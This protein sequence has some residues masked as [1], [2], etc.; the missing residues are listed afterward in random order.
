VV[1]CIRALWGLVLCAIVLTPFAAAQVFVTS[2]QSTLRVAAGDTVQSKL[3]LSNP[4]DREYFASATITGAF[5]ADTTVMPAQVTVPPRGRTSLN[6]SL[7]V[8]D[9]TRSGS[10]ETTV[11]LAVVDT[12]TGQTFDRTMRFQ[13][14]VERQARFL[15]LFAPP[16]AAPFD[17]GW[18][19]VALEVIA[20]AIIASVVALLARLVVS[21]LA[22]RTTKETRAK[23][24]GRIAGP[25]WYLTFVLG[26]NFSLRLVPRGPFVDLFVR[27]TNLAALI[28]GAFAAYR[29][30][31]AMLVY[32]ER[33]HAAR[34]GARAAAVLVPILEK[35]AAVGIVGF[36]AI[37]GLRL[38]GVD[39][40]VLL[41]GGVV[42]GLVLSFAAQDTLSNFFSG[43]FLLI[44]RPFTEGDEIRLETDDV[45]RVDHIGLRSTRLFHFRHDQ[46]M[47]VPNNE[48]ATKR[49]VNMSRPDGTYRLHVELDVAYNVNLRE[50]RDLL[51]ELATKEPDVVSGP[52]R[53]PVVWLRDLGE[54]GIRVQLRVYIPS[55]RHRNPVRTA[56]MLAIKETFE[57]RG[58]EI[59]RPQHEVWLRE[60]R[61]RPA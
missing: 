39:L 26:L 18:P 48:L 30:I 2:D 10:Y 4:T 37:Y 7:T 57:A 17:D 61:P 15:G 28:I 33:H 27:L 47:V 53:D 51:V 20:W 22:L 31:S 49:V 56:L 11:D 3:E 12:S 46:E 52:G 19:L 54:S 32:Y 9:S 55:S 16:L 35:L 34:H 59:P 44:D 50:V 24:T 8:V 36:A 23:M 42:A 5:A 29:V 6:L 21:Q 13:V 58:I 43:M 45:C 60:P 25:A 14:V 38:L 1:R 40:A 41:T